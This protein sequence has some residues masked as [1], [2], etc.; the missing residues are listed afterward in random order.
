MTTS[1]GSMM[2]RDLER[3]AANPTP[4]IGRPVTDQNVIDDFEFR[5]KNAGSSRAQ[6]SEAW[7]ARL[8]QEAEEKALLP[9]THGTPP[10]GKTLAGWK[11]WRDGLRDELDGLHVGAEGLRKHLEAPEATQRSLA[12][13][14]ASGARRMLAGMGIGTAEPELESA[15][16]PGQLEARLAAE[17]RASAE[18]SAALEIV[19]EK[20]AVTEKQLAAIE[21]RADEFVRPAL[22]ELAEPLGTRYVKVINELAEV[23]SLIWA[24]E[25]MARDL[26]WGSGW[27]G[28]EKLDLPLTGLASTKLVPPAKFRVRVSDAHRAFWKNARNTLLA[29]PKAKISL[30]KAA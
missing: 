17:K 11:A 15:L 13:A 8:K 27:H 20:I 24:A 29:D 12:E 6:I 18:A 19:N 22:R 28:F 1:P 9:F 14:I 3:M 7:A 16:A 5:A 2:R 23:M 21:A 25:P 30:P 4:L 26:E 10:G